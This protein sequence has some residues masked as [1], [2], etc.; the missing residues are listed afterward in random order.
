[1][2]FCRL[3]S[4]LLVTI[5]ICSAQDRGCTLEQVM[6]ST[7]PTE[8]TSA[9]HANRIAWVFNSKGERNVWIA[10]APNF[11]ARQITHYQGDDGP[12]ILAL[13]L[14][15]DGKTAVYA[16]G[17]ELNSTGNV[18][19]PT[20]ET[21][22]PKQQVWAVDVETGKTQLLGA[23]GCE[24]EGCED[25]QISPDGKSVLWVT[26]H[27]IWMSPVAG[28]QP[29]R[30]LTQLRGDES[31]PQWSPDGKQIAFQS[32]RR[33]H[34]FIAIYDIATERVRY[35][36]PSVDRDFAPR[37]SP[38]G[39]QIVFIRTP[40]A[41]NYL[42]VI[43]QSPRP[44]AL[45]LADAATAEARELWHS[46]KGLAD[47]LPPFAAKSLKF[48]VSGRIVFDS[49]MDGRNHLY[50]VSIHTILGEQPVI[51]TPGDFDVED[52][53]LTPDRAAVLFTSNQ[54]DVDRR[55][56]WRVDLTTGFESGKS[57]GPFRPTALSQ[58]AT[59]EWRPLMIADGTVVCLG[60]SG[61]SP[62]MPYR[63]TRKGREMIADNAL[64]ADF[65]SGQ[66]FEPQQVTFR[67][68]DGM[69]IPAQLFI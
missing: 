51:L 20:S 32:D 58:G 59:I 14:T 17:S 39:K 62:A 18:A 55:H 41:Q 27:H 23:M 48:G 56:I 53:E 22:E 68:E 34:S 69:E 6:S 11:A 65:P 64:P 7:F 38:D 5:A 24:Q 8:L 66:L 16:R 10:D 40:G 61:T 19:N 46:G 60:S 4:V 54:T 33:D 30:Q 45:W 13:A 28:D 2:K 37:W 12:D 15:T 44:W 47:S 26:K 31:N 57:W 52:V 3:L 29:A 50:A 42:P 1:M 25:I 49:E 63:L 43:P 67:S 21:K 9:A 35:V 36:S